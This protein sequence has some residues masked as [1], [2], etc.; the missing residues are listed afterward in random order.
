KENGRASLSDSVNTQFS[1]SIF[2]S[3]GVCGSCSLRRSSSSPQCSLT[4]S[5]S[6][7]SASAS[8]PGQPAGLALAGQGCGSNQA[9]CWV[10]G[11]PPSD[12]GHGAA[13]I[14]WCD[15]GCARASMLALPR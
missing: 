1:V 4:T 13:L 6:L 3:S 7:Q 14:G 10:G 15:I 2:S 5:A 12:A 11:D 9:S 8:A